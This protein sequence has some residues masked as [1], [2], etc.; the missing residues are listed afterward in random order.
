MAN[1]VFPDSALIP[2]Q[3]RILAAGVHYHL[4]TISFTVT[5]AT[6]LASFTE[7]ALAGYAPILV[8][9]ADWALQGVVGHQGISQAAPITYITSD[10]PG[11]NIY[12]VYVTDVTD[13][14]LLWGYTLDAG[15]MFNAANPLSVTPYLG[16]FS[17]NG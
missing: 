12:Q 4:G 5:K 3:N 14:I 8:A 9:L 6:L 17:T 11:E 1:L 16:D 7:C 13:A 2:V 15:V 10:V